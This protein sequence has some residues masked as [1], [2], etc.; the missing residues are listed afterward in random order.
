MVHHLVADLLTRPDVVAGVREVAGVGV[1][2]GPAAPVLGEDP[3]LRGDVVV[4]PV[5]ARGVEVSAEIPVAVDLAVVVTAP[6]DLV[7]RRVVALAGEEVADG[8][9]LHPHVVGLVDQDPVTAETTTLPAPG[10][11]VLSGFP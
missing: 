7:A 1:V 8:E 4:A 5:G 9:V 10:A 3:V 2:P 6:P 11:E